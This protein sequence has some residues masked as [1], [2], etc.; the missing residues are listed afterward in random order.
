MTNREARTKTAGVRHVPVSAWHGMAR[1]GR[2]GER[3]DS[4]N[5][6]LMRRTACGK[7]PAASIV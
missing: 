5:S 4:A 6:A 1:T 2:H 7:K 3:G